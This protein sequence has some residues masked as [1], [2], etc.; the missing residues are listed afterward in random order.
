MCQPRGNCSAVALV[1]S[2]CI[3]K[4]LGGYTPI[5]VKVT[6]AVMKLWLVA[7]FPLKHGKT[8]LRLLACLWENSNGDII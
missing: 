3:L 7:L 2:G 6:I 8:L 5:L 4:T 1:R